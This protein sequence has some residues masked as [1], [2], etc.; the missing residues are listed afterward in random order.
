MELS[1]FVCNSFGGKAPAP[2]LPKTLG[3]YA[4]HACQERRDILLALVFHAF[5]MA[6]HRMVGCTPAHFDHFPSTENASKAFP[7]RPP[8]FHNRRGLPSSLPRLRALAH[9]SL[10]LASSSVNGEPGADLDEWEPYAGGGDNSLNP[11]RRRRISRMR[12][13]HLS[14]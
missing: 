11:A 9:R 5:R 3:S 6:F 1:T 7:G 14:R 2:V 8:N 10:N 13:L 4:L 12:S